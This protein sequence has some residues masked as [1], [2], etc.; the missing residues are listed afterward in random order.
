MASN[1]METEDKETQFEEDMQIKEEPPD[2]SEEVD[3]AVS[4]MDNKDESQSDEEGD[5]EPQMRLLLRPW[6]EAQIESGEIPGLNWID[7]ERTLFRIP[8]KHGAKTTFTATD[9][10]IFKKWSIHTG[11]FH[12][13][14]DPNYAMLKTR[15]RMAINKAPD[16]EEVKELRN[17]E[18][19]S[20]FKAFRFLPNPKCGR[21]QSSGHVSTSEEEEDDCKLDV[22]EQRSPLLEPKSEKT[23]GG[24]GLLE[25]TSPLLVPKSETSSLLNTECCDEM[26]LHQP[27]LLAEN[28]S[29]SNGDNQE[30]SIMTVAVNQV[31]VTSAYLSEETMGDKR[32]R[33][34]ESK[35]ENLM[36]SFC[37]SFMKPQSVDVPKVAH[38]PGLPIS[39]IP[40]TV[41]SET[42]M[43]QSQ[44]DSDQKPNVL[45][46]KPETK[47]MNCQSTEMTVSSKI[48][49]SNLQRKNRTLYSFL[50]TED[51]PKEDRRP[52]ILRKKPK[53]YVIL[54]QKTA[55]K[56]DSISQPVQS[57]LVDNNSPV[58]VQAVSNDDTSSSVAAQAIPVSCSNN[59]DV[60]S[61]EGNMRVNNSETSQ[62]E[63]T[64]AVS[65]NEITRRIKKILTAKNDKTKLYLISDS[66]SDL[67]KY[68]V[69]DPQMKILNRFK[70]T[71]TITRD[72]SGP[73]PNQTNP[74]HFT[75]VKRN[76]EPVKDIGFQL[77]DQLQTDTNTL[78]QSKYMSIHVGQRREGIIPEN[79]ES[80]STVQREGSVDKPAQETQGAD[81]PEQE[82]QDVAKSEQ[83]VTWKAVKQTTPSG[84]NVAV[85]TKVASSNI[86]NQPVPVL[87]IRNLHQ[88][89]TL[90]PSF[91]TSTEQTNQTD[92]SPLQVSLTDSSKDEPLPLVIS[93]V[94]SLSGEGQK[95]DD[96][97][98]SNP[99]KEEKVLPKHDHSG[100]LSEAG[101]KTKPAVSSSAT[102]PSFLVHAVRTGRTMSVVKIIPTTKS[103][104]QSAFSCVQNK[105]ENPPKIWSRAHPRKAKE[106][107]MV[108]I[109]EEAQTNT[110]DEDS[111]DDGSEVRDKLLG[112][113]D[114]SVQFPEDSDDCSLVSKGDSNIHGQG[115]STYFTKEGNALAG[116]LL[117]S[118]KQLKYMGTRNFFK[119]MDSG[120]SYLFCEICGRLLT[121]TYRHRYAHRRFPE[122]CLWILA[123]KTCRPEHK[124]QMCCCGKKSIKMGIDMYK[125]HQ[126]NCQAFA[127][128]TS[129]MT[130]QTIQNFSCW[131]CPAKFPT[132]LK[133]KNH[134]Q[135]AH[136]SQPPILVDLAVTKSQSKWFLCPDSNCFFMALRAQT[137]MRHAKAFHNSTDI[138]CHAALEQLAIMEDPLE[139]DQ[140]EEELLNADGIEVLIA[141]E[142]TTKAKETELLSENGGFGKQ[143]EESL[144]SDGPEK[145]ELSSCNEATYA[146]SF[147]DYIEQR[148][149]LMG[150]NYG[151]LCV[152]CNFNSMREMPMKVHILECHPGREVVMVDLRRR[153]RKQ[154]MLA[155]FCEDRNC[156]IASPLMH[157]HTPEDIYF[158]KPEKK[159]RQN[160]FLKPDM[161]LS[162]SANDTDCDIIVNESLIKIDQDEED[163]KSSES[164]EM[165]QEDR[166]ESQ[167]VPHIYET[168]KVQRNFFSDE[169]LLQS[170]LG[171]KCKY[172]DYQSLQSMDIKMHILDVHINSN[173]VMVNLDRLRGKL[174]SKMFFCK[175]R[176]CDIFNLNKHIHSNGQVI[177][178]SADIVRRNR[179]K[180]EIILTQPRRRD[181]RGNNLRRGIGPEK[182][183]GVESDSET[184]DSGSKDSFQEELRAYTKVTLGKR[185]RGEDSNSED[186]FHTMN[187]ISAEPT[188]PF[189]SLDS[190]QEIEQEGRH[191]SEREDVPHEHE[192][193]EDQRR[194]GE[195]LSRWSLGYKCY[196][197]DYKSVLG[198]DVKSH[199]L[200]TH[201]NWEP[202]IVNLDKRQSRLASKMYC[203]EDRAC[204]ILDF[205]RHSHLDSGRV[206]FKPVDVKKRKKIKKEKAL[207]QMSLRHLG[208]DS[209]HNKDLDIESDSGNVDSRDLFHAMNEISTELPVHTR[210]SSS[211]NEPLVYLDHDTS[212]SISSEILEHQMR[213]QRKEEKET[214]KSM[215]DSDLESSKPLQEDI[216][217]DSSG[218]HT[219]E[220]TGKYLHGQDPYEKMLTHA[221][222]PLF[223]SSR[224][225][226]TILSR[227]EV[228]EEFSVEVEDGSVNFKPRVKQAK[229]GRVQQC[230]YC[231]D[232]YI[233]DDLDRMRMHF[234]TDHKGQEWLVFGCLRS[235]DK[236]QTLY[237]CPSINCPTI[238]PSK[239]ELLKHE[240]EH[241]Y[242]CYPGI[243]YKKPSY[244]CQFESAN[245]KDMRM[246]IEACHR[247]EVFKVFRDKLRAQRKQMAKVFVCL[248]PECELLMMTEDLFLE[249]KEAAHT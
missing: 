60:G 217:F 111:G 195:V 190:A 8:W 237:V 62:S 75:Y 107:A 149:T 85:L 151:Y 186:S 82:S 126:T 53:I 68:E 131:Y 198:I 136:A 177:F 236:H 94:R 166:S 221:V 197:C 96:M 208:K 141:Y 55:L 102:A 223:P 185:K 117:K 164:Q 106:K 24:C 180:K 114:K 189:Y 103:G 140:E 84:N 222:S 170:S 238:K 72:H 175:K 101:M 187:E 39:D 206:V 110:N 89:D 167:G 163:W 35:S 243:G 65:H 69:K 33:T 100:D 48:F 5:G 184:L 15:L 124:F 225:K 9:G 242:Q 228:V 244:S 97:S 178:Q 207:T 249:H 30:K 118:E 56:P 247:S 17:K 50:T 248:L 179:I 147:E 171:Y 133:G 45:K 22:L 123:P 44:D 14:E 157:W 116:K 172:C 66:D 150:R 130:T 104:V 196:Y 211:F 88:K 192:A 4:K 26:S 99:T 92:T 132:F 122:I 152:H 28:G 245:L 98:K 43:Q 87:L 86:P 135:V 202:V 204:E 36:Q 58:T 220:T 49:P 115:Q 79:K 168:T 239:E 2:D 73:E 38:S 159:A 127:S 224:R 145:G 71:T 19:D 18:G 52:R 20:Q 27:A 25:Q 155:Y 176:T 80:I 137:I 146:E 31:P 13:G 201:C 81:K 194:L 76:I 83:L 109:H 47:E 165:V 215:S 160:Q 231:R 188:N 209:G 41:E 64:S 32:Q 173:P 91:L 232:G 59:D 203:C 54:H 3:Y 144:A 112:K 193:K 162:D 143:V 233:S 218:C 93:D 229:K 191:K 227:Q 240:A 70:P 16:I 23:E 199:I 11:R 174:A 210:G 119:A 10:L 139:R 214:N 74:Q 138:M 29:G 95:Q 235:N 134:L 7:N 125:G 213:L 12:D 34:D 90:P 6:L 108:K 161:E 142:E 246:H 182:G 40:K 241:S 21:G 51:D 77:M 212:G 113:L 181:D 154:S 105:V 128:R 1:R 226:Q 200:D 129:L 230:F 219:S 205:S 57:L 46:R 37:P 158:T 67:T 216:E 63:V 121:T 156:D 183:F 169:R 120:N 234:Q 42:D 148:R 153:Q 61:V 78:A